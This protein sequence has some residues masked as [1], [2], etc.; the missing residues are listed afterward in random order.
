MP[1]RCSRREPRA[2]RVHS[3]IASYK[4]SQDFHGLAPRSKAD[5]LKHIAKVEIAFGDMPLPRSTIR[6]SR[7]ISSNGAMAWRTRRAR[8]TIH[9]WCSAACCPGRAPADYGLSPARAGRAALS[10][11]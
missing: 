6:G 3:V 7:A 10:C 9:G 8:P 4:A 11:R 5:Y 1:R 2:D